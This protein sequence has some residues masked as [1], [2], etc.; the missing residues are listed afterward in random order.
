MRKIAN[1]AYT[2]IFLVL[3][4]GMGLFSYI[5]LAKF[6]INQEID[7]NEWTPEL[8]TKFETD[9]ASTFCG[10]FSFVNLNGA[11]SNVLSQPSMNGIYKLRNGHLIRPEAYISDTEIEYYADEVIKYAEFCKTRGI[12]VLFVQPILKLDEENKQL[13]VGVEDYSNENVDSFLEYLKSSNIDVLDIRQCM[14]DDGMD[15]YDYTYITDHH[16]TTEGCFYT[17]GK[18]VEWINENMNVSY[19]PQIVDLNNYEIITYHNWHL[20]SYGQRVGEYYAGI[21]DYNLIVPQFDVSF[22]DNEGNRHTFY[23][24]AVNEEIFERRDATSRYTYDYALRCPSG[25]ASTSRDCKVLFVS[26]SYAT[27]IAPYIKLAYSDYYF[28]YYASGFNSDLVIETNPDIVI[29]MP[30]YISAFDAG[31]VFK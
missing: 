24:E 26:D 20:G 5:N 11:V 29:L 9:V 6:Y 18:I 14:K 10:K 15:L 2:T 12:T 1:Y 17:Y 31:A 8:G 7:Y 23:E 3:V 4:L 22:I 27:A 25:I 30:Y 16:W 13:P 19:D 21:D 28:Q